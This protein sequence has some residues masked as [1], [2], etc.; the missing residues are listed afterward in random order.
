MKSNKEGSE[1]LPK[2]THTN[3]DEKTTVLSGISAD[4]GTTDGGMEAW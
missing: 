4:K 3:K 2:H 1:S